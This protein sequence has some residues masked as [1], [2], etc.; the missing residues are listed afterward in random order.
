MTT[1]ACGDMQRFL[2]GN[3]AGILP[4]QSSV[5]CRTVQQRPLQGGPMTDP[6]N[7][8]LAVRLR[9]GTLGNG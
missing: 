7:L 4:Y 9:P 2:Y 8:Q 3:W 6:E 5:R 1:A